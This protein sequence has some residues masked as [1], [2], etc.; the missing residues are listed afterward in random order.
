MAEKLGIHPMSDDACPCCGTSEV[1][2]RDSLYFC[3]RCHHRW[4]SDSQENMQAHYATQSGRNALPEHYIKR[5]LD[6]RYAA[7]HDYLDNGMHV[8]E[9]GCAEGDLGGLIKSHFNLHYAGVELS[10]DKQKASQVLD[11]VCEQ[12]AQ[13]PQHR[14]DLLLAFHVLEHIADLN[15]ALSQ[16]LQLLTPT[17]KLVIEVPNQ[18]GHPWI[19]T[20]RNSEHCHQFDTASLLLLMRR[21]GLTVSLLQTGMFESPCYPDSIRIVATRELSPAQRVERLVTA[22][23]STIGEPFDV[24]AV[25]GDFATYV[26]PSLDFLPIIQ[27]FDSVAQNRLIAGKNVEHFSLHKNAGRPVLI[28]SFRYEDDIAKQLLAAGVAQQRIFRLSDV[29]MQVGHHV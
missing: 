10:K 24:C 14:Y 21:H 6:E 1:G 25:G 11:V 18:S 8:V 19:E 26:A 23:T 2:L 15:Q 13:L 4:R 29:L 12:P 5:K 3:D 9:I 27:L 7:L 28:A 22:L 20:D 16:W 17:A